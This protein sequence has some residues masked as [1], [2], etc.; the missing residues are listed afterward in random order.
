MHTWKP[1]ENTGVFLPCSLSYSLE[2]RS[3]SDSES[4]FSRLAGWWAPRTC[5]SAPQCW[6][7]RNIVYNQL[8]YMGSKYSHSDAMCKNECSYW[9]KPTTHT[10]FAGPFPQLQSCFY[11]VPYMYCTVNLQSANKWR[12]EMLVAQLPKLQWEPLEWS[13]LPGVREQISCVFCSS[14][15]YCF[16]DHVLNILSY[17]IL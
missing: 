17:L 12:Q 14:Y 5:L 2:T 7:N 1:E 4:Q 11:K 15:V 9:A 16:I 3:V 6:G 8:V 13:P 10:H